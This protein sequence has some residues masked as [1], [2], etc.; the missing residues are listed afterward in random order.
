MNPRER[1]HRLA[2]KLNARI[3]VFTE[4]DLCVTIAAP[5]GTTWSC[6]PG[7]HVLVSYQ[8]DDDPYTAWEDALERMRRGLRTCGCPHCAKDKGAESWGRWDGGANAQPGAEN[9]YG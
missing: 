4:G 1:A 3:E 7:S 8:R 2:E 9:H 6:D 5:H